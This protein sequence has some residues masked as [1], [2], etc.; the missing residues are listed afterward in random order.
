MSS[1]NDTWKIIAVTSTLS[2]AI[3]SSA[4]AANDASAYSDPR[5]R[6]HA[7]RDLAQQDGLIVRSRG[8]RIIVAGGDKYNKIDGGGQYNKIDSSRGK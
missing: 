7:V 3:T 2:V 1:N 6:L 5:A 4:L 8:E